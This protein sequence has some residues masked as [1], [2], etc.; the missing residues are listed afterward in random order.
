MTDPK[1]LKA[2]ADGLDGVA[3]YAD[4]ID[5]L[6]YRR[7]C[8]MVPAGRAELAAQASSAEQVVAIV[9]EAA[10]HA[11]PVYVRGGGTM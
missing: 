8:S 5:L 6:N 11:T 10:A 2:V 7:D 4:P 1:V 9:S 3:L